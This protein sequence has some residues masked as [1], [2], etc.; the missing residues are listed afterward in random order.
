MKSTTS[1]AGTN[2]EAQFLSLIK[3]L[4]S[5]HPL[6]LSKAVVKTFSR[7]FLVGMNSMREEEKIINPN[8]VPPIRNCDANPQTMTLIHPGIRNWLEF[9]LK[10]NTPPKDEDID[11][12]CGKDNEDKLKNEYPWQVMKLYNDF[13]VELVV[14]ILGNNQKGDR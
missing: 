3:I 6:I 12:E 5:K 14:S 2:E 13:L 9:Y 7:H 4:K 11:C 10:I 1:S 8:V